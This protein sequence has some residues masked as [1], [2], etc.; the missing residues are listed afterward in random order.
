MLLLLLILIMAYKKKITVLHTRAA[1]AHYSFTD[2]LESYTHTMTK[3]FITI[4]R[5][6]D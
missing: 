6:T 2:L 5:K 3:F 4:D 1:K